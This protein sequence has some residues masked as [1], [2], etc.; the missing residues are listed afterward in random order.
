MLCHTIIQLLS[1]LEWAQILPNIW[2]Y[3]YDL[4]WQVQSFTF[5][6]GFLASLIRFWNINITLFKKTLR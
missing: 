3:A 2:N 5:W 4:I 1:L 6:K